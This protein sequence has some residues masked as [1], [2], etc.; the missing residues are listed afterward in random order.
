MQF[1]HVLMT[2]CVCELEGPERLGL[3]SP[4]EFARLWFPW[5]TR[6]RS[7]V[8]EAD[9]WSPSKGSGSQTAP[10][11]WSPGS[12]VNPGE[13]TKEE[14]L[15]VGRTMRRHFHMPVKSQ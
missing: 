3:T 1:V 8:N 6:A 7:E 5:R 13:K 2:V 14:E 11:G 15:S 12:P 9:W 10:S 4:G